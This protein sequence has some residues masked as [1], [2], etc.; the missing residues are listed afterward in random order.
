ML[1]N[2]EVLVAG[3]YVTSTEIYSPTGGVWTMVAPMNTARSYHTATLLPSGKVLVTG[4]NGLIEGYLT[5]TELYDPA[6][7]VWTLAGA[8]NIARRNQISHLAAKRQSVD[9]G[10]LQR[11]KPVSG[12]HRI[13]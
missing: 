2:G 11:Y 1:A 12:Q 4:G 8:L 6:T 13:I 5:N 10:R 9:Y 3:S 7:N